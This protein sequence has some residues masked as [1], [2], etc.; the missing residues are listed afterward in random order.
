MLMMSVGS[1]EDETPPVAMAS[2]RE[3]PDE[4]IRA[5]ESAALSRDRAKFANLLEQTLRLTR[6]KAERIVSDPSGEPLL[7]AAKAVGMPPIVLQRVLMFID[8][9]IGESVQRVFELAALYERMHM[10]AALRI[11]ES[12]RGT[13]T[14]RPRRPAHRPMYHDDEATRVRRGGLARRSAESAR[15]QPPPQTELRERQLK[16]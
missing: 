11:I 8:P 3:L 15:P 13:E 6:E 10:Q 1:A 9:A 16:T 4:T 12:L 5:L 2:P 7:V 14:A